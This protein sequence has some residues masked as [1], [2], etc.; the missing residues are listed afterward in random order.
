M[1]IY[2]PGLCTVMALGLTLSGCSGDDDSDMPQSPVA[3]TKTVTI[4][5]VEYHP[6]PGQFVNEMPA[7][8]SGMTA[9]QMQQAALSDLQ[10]GRGVSLGAFGG[11]IIMTL[12]EPINHRADGRDFKVLGNAFSGSAEPGVVEVSADG[13]QW[14]ALS[15]QDWSQATRNFTITYYQ[16][17]AD[18]TQAHYI[19]WTAASGE[20]GWISR[21]PGFHTDHPF[22]PAWEEGVTSLTFTATRLP[23]N[24]SYDQA[25]G[26]YK[27]EAMWGYAD[28]YPNTSAD[29]WLNLAN[30]VD[31]SNNPVTVSS[32]R[33]I[34]VTTGVLDSNSVTGECSTE[35]MG[36]QVQTD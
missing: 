19:R 25:T 16:P 33:Y 21:N 6:A 26:N 11:Y 2:I 5:A 15:G 29:S 31:A 30:A 23:D 10:R 28:S 8:T 4:S 12:S 32:I 36:I 22:F 35:V 7:Y 9:Q 14:Y 13:S 20:S 3:G 27:G 34:K 1:K 17:A 18:A 24:W